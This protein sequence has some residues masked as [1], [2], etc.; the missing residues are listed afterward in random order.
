MESSGKFARAWLLVLVSAVA[1]LVLAAVMLPVIGGLGLVAKAGATQFEQLPTALKAP[2]LPQRSKVLAADGSTLA[3]FYY[4]NR[5]AVRSL[6]DISPAMRQAIVAIED[7]RFYEHGGVDLKGVA[8]AAWADATNGQVVQGASTITQQYVRRVLV[9]KADTEKGK[10]AAVADTI[11]RKL[12]EARY[13]IALENRLSKRQILLRYLNIAY[14]GDGAYG[15]G[16]AAEHYFGIPAKNLSVPQAALLAGLVQNPSAYDPV[17]HKDVARTRRDTVL[18][19]MYHQ[20]VITADQEQRAIASPLG[21]RVKD[22]GTG[23][24]LSSAPFFCAYAIRRF[25]ANPAFGQTRTDRTNLLL[26]GGLTI[27]TTLRPKVE[28]AARRAVRNNVA[29]DSRFVGAEAL[30]QPGTGKVEGIAI[31]RPYGSGKHQT[32]IDYAVNKKYGG[33]GGFQAGSTFKMFTLT[34]ALQAGVGL[35]HSVYAPYRLP[36]SSLDHGFVNCAGHEQ[37]Y[38]TKGGKGPH[39]AASG[40]A[41][42]FTLRQA[43]VHSV[44]TYYIQLEQRL[45]TCKPFRAAKSMGVTR[46][47]GGRLGRDPSFTLGTYG[48]SPLAIASAFATLGEGDVLPAVRHHLG[49][50]EDR[51]DDGPAEPLLPTGN[52]FR[53][54]E[55]RDRRAQGRAHQGHGGWEGHRPPRGW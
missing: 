7:A 49:D 45:G 52:L 29:K 22:V 41:G 9:E 21:L 11:G 50:D 24:E 55:H 31:S 4:Q 42:S 19:K 26:R 39:N 46:G 6:H 18:R 8:R 1:G 12:R 25:Q 32:T 30:V 28:K 47:N 13:A 40:E 35:K 37:K 36:A 38:D 17:H 16:T 20:Q 34:A 15:V 14:F 10:K 3:T 44:N 53:A 48:V 51:Q 43:T 54:C 23:C 5:I 33:S 27:K 2:P